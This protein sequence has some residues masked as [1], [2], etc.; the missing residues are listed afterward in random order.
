MI[1]NQLARIFVMVELFLQLPVELHPHSL[2]Q[3]LLSLE[4]MQ[5][6]HPPTRQAQWLRLILFPLFS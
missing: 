5:F 2:E 6:L 4:Q 1:V 3:A